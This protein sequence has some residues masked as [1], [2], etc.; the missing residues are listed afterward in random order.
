MDWD[1]VRNYSSLYFQGAL[2]TFYISILAIICATILGYFVALM[3]LSSIRTLNVV[4][5]IYVWIFRGVPLLL[6]LFW[7]YY[8]TPFGITLTA[9]TAGLVAMSINSASFKSEIIRAGIMA[10]DKGQLEAA[11]A[12]G[13]NP[14]Q[15]YA[16][17]DSASSA[18]H[19]STLF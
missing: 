3:R 12:I 10:V 8:A 4:S 11:E 19:D 9:F 17:Y 16:Y 5:F 1:I 6:T 2:V 13:M 7:F 14:L 18:T 15:N